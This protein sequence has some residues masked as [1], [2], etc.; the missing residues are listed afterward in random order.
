M[1]WIPS[2]SKTRRA[3]GSSPAVTSSPVS[4]EILVIPCR[5]APIMSD[6]MARRFL[7]RQTIC[8][9]GSKPY[10]FI[11]IAVVVFEAWAWAAGLSVALTASNQGANRAA[12]FSTDAIPPPSTDG[13]SAVKTKSSV[14]SNFSR[15]VDIS[16]LYLLL[17]NQ[18]VSVDRAWL[19][20]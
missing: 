8:I 9:I 18:P 12:F 2:T 13:N 6:W 7:S 1:A 4:R 17:T 16:G 19:L 15:R 3:S 20:S 11:A 14:F 10:I 5:D